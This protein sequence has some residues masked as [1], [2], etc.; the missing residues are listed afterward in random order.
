MVLIVKALDKKGQLPV[1]NLHVSAQLFN[2][3]S[4]PFIDVI[5]L[6]LAILNQVKKVYNFAGSN[7]SVSL[8]MDIHIV[9]SIAQINR[10]KLLFCI[11]DEVRNGNPAEADF[12]G[13][14]VALNKNILDTII[15]GANT[16]T[17][18]HELGHI[19]GWEHP[20]ARGKY[21]SINLEADKVYEQSM[22]ETERKKN[23]MSQTWYIQTAGLIANE[24]TELTFGQMELLHKNF[25]AKKLNN[26]Y[27]IKGWLWWKRLV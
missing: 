5:K 22:T 25:Q 3:S 26:N 9:S 20:H 7:F 13:L 24:G 1:F 14:R 27:H 6:R 16:R 17:I 8:V 12:K 18:P 4:D 15:S 11:Q 21:E 23:L 2:N 10:N 19:F